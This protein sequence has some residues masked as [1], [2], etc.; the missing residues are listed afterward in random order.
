MTKTYK[1]KKQSFKVW[2]YFSKLN[3]WSTQVQHTKAIG[4]FIM[5]P[6]KNV[7]I[8]E[9]CMKHSLTSKWV[10]CMLFAGSNHLFLCFIILFHHNEEKRGTINQN[11]IFFSLFSLF[12]WKRW[13]KWKLQKDRISISK[14][15]AKQLFACENTQHLEYMGLP[16]SL[17]NSCRWKDLKISCR[18]NFWPYNKICTV[19]TKSFVIENF[20]TKF[21]LF[22][23]T[24]LFKFINWP[25]NSCLLSNNES[26]IL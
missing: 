24:I 12:D 21:A 11:G 26:K 18:C 1:V 14:Q 20:L 7:E 4:C 9:T 19:K 6:V 3:N 10:L 15:H 8:T 16:A 2:V 13:K 22:L 23:S 5:P 17:L 25:F